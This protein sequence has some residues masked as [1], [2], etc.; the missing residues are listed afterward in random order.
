MTLLQLFKAIHFIYFLIR[1]T[2][3]DIPFI[4]SYFHSYF[5]NVDLVK[6]NYFTILQ[7]YIFIL[8][9]KIFPTK[10]YWV[11]HWLNHRYC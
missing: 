4:S 7:K 10:G 8:Y 5:I 1:I 3:Q 11:F 9:C 2:Y 6:R